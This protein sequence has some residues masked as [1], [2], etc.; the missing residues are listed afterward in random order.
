MS[1]PLPPDAGNFCLIRLPEV[2]A[3]TG[4]SRSAIYARMQA[5]DFPQPVHL[6][7][8]SRAWPEHE[9]VAWCQARIAA[10]DAKVAS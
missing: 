6:G 3:R 1:K 9:V 5:G 2:R 7:E 10:R 4:L 8:R